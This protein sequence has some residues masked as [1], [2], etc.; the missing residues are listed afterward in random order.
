MMLLAEAAVKAR[1]TA[2]IALREACE[3][4]AC[5]ATELHRAFM[6]DALRPVPA[7]MTELARK[8]DGITP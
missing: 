7:D 8:L 1:L 5:S 3:G 2:A 4:R 6:F